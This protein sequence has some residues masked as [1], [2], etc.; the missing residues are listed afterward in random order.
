[1]HKRRRNKLLLIM[2]SLFFFGFAIALVLVALRNN[3]SLY[4][5]PTELVHQHPNSQSQ[6]RLGGL[7][8]KHSVHHRLHSLFV[9]FDLTDYNN[10]VQVHYTGLLPTLFREG[11]GIIAE[12]HLDK[13]GVFEAAS[14]LAKH[15]AN[16]HPP[17]IPRGQVVQEYA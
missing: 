4:L 3:I 5:T 14:V 13:Y 16:Y 11:Q 12:G 2:S 6:L 15:D 10:R 7:V 1:M 9:T 8:V 17:N